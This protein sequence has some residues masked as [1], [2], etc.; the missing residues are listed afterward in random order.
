MKNQETDTKKGLIAAYI[1]EKSGKGVLIDWPEINQWKP[2]QGL[3]WVHLDY[4]NKQARAWLQEDSN[5]DPIVKEALLEEETRPRYSSINGGLLVT[6]RGVNLNPGADPEDMV[7]IR[8]W[9]DKVRI[10]STRGRYMPSEK[11]M[12]KAIEDGQGPDSSSQFLIDLTYYMIE[13]IADVIDNIEVKI[14]HIDDEI[15]KKEDA[16]GKSQQELREFRRKIMTLRR[17]LAPQRD[18]MLRL[19]AERI[20]WFDDRD[21]LHLK[22]IAEIISR[23]IEDLEE[24]KEQ[25]NIT[26]EQILSQ[27]SNQANRRMYLLSLIAS[28]FLPLTFV[29]GLLGINVGGIPGS[30]NPFA[31]SLITGVLV[32]IAVFMYIYLKL[33]KWM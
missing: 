17:Y 13:Q 28:I 10:I 7:A 5:L 29:T 20:E 12:Y 8:L 21:R 19:A 16:T 26:Q 27:I 11:S 1:I 23:N 30:H 25:I 2:K 15:N 24:A 18:V 4:N 6:L 14:D 22:E 33:K 3:L 31:F 32:A 9:I